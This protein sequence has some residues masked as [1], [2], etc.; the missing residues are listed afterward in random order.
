MECYECGGE[1]LTGF[2]Y[3]V[4]DDG[5]WFPVCCLACERLYNE[6]RLEREE[7]LRVL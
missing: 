2:L 4:E 6:K 5:K 3:E 1:V 7:E